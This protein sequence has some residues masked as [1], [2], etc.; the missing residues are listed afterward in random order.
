MRNKITTFR[1]IAK[2]LNS[3]CATLIGSSFDPF[4]SYYFRLLNWA[5][6]QSRP[7][8]A[9][10][11][12]DEMIS[13]R[14]SFVLPS[15]NQ[16]KRVKNIAKLNFVDYV[17]LSRKLA[18][19][20]WCLKALRPKFVI[21]QHDNPVYHKKLFS[22]L[23]QYFPQVHF[24]VAPFKQERNFQSQAVS[25]SSARNIFK[26]YR[27]KICKRLILL[28]K[29]SEAQIGKISAIL[30]YEDKIVAEAYNSDKGEHAEI[31]LLSQNRLNKT[32]D[33]Y[34]LYVLIPPCI[35]CAEAIFRSNIKKVYYLYNYG[36]NLG[37]KYLKSKGVS[38]KKYI[39][40][41]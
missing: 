37:I 35:M 13:I 23:S 7:L 29:K 2:S 19:D 12:P 32:L 18:H 20:P 8:V 15:E 34:S 41:R 36:D 38:I 3:H 1:K 4:G 22:V 40:K 39:G 28:A 24:K 10:V 17:I 26:D 33:K 6:Q 25:L 16:Y 27:N 31:L 9:I 30:T 14:R 11:H 5:S 21:F